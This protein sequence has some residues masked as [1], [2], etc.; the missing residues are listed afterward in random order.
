MLDEH[1]ITSSSFEFGL[2]FK[3][4]IRR[5]HA[6]ILSKSIKDFKPLTG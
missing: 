1:L 4:V 6:V 5:Y 3:A 2:P